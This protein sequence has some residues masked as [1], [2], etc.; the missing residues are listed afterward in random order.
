M[1]ESEYFD[2]LEV[3]GKLVFESV[4]LACRPSVC[5]AGPDARRANKARLAEMGEE[6]ARLAGRRRFREYQQQNAGW[7]LPSAALNLQLLSRNI[8]GYCAK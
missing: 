5:P 8:R 6:A 3:L 2:L 4:E 7:S 1:R